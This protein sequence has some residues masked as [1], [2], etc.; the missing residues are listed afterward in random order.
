MS[1]LETLGFALSGL[2]LVASGATVSDV[3]ALTLTAAENVTLSTQSATAYPA[4]IGYPV[5]WFD[6]SET[7]GWTF[8]P[9][10]DVT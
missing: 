9:A 7:N 6:A 5:Y 4:D 10:G 3:N 1:N 8:S 2:A